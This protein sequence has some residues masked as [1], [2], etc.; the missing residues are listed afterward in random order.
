MNRI[1]AIDYGR[2]RVGL[3]VTNDNNQFIKSLDVLKFNCPTF[4]NKLIKIIRDNQINL[5]VLGTPVAEELTPI[6]IEIRNLKKAIENKIDNIKVVSWDE[7][8]SS[9]EANLLIRQMYAKKKS[10][11]LAG[12]QKAD[13]IAAAIILKEYCSSQLQQKTLDIK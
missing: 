2:K 10:R 7:S 9:V 4:W 5:I 13:S 6:Q 8:Y 3:A 12:K 1:L 11:R